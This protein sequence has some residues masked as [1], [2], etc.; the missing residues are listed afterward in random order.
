MVEKTQLNTGIIG[1]G[2]IATRGHIPGYQRL[3]GVQVLAICDVDEARA[4]S[5]AEEF[6]IPH[7]FT[8]YHDLLAM[9]EID[10]VSVCPPNR[11]HAEMSIAA[12]EAGKHVLCDKPMAMNAAEAR[13]MVAAA[14]RSGNFLTL[15]LHNRYHPE[16]Q[17]LKRIVDGGTLGEIY[18]AK[19]SLLRRTGIPGYGSWFTN[20]DL[21]GAGALFDIGVHILDL[22]LYIIGHRLPVSV[23]GATF[24]KMGTRQRG[25]GNWGIE[26]HREGQ[27]RFD[28]DD[29]ATAFMRFD[30]G[31]VLI[32]D[33]S[34][35]GYARS[36][37]RLQFWG[38]EGGAEI[39]SLWA[40]E[41]APLRL[42][43]DLNGLPTEARPAVPRASVGSYFAAIEE[44]VNCVREGRQPPITPQQGL[45]VTQILDAILESASTGR[46]VRLA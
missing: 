27:A 6:H 40:D 31:A 36:E 8:N 46:E 42:Q 23:S 30:D 3:P 32:V 15:G 29:L 26:I 41:G 7:V 24:A 1:A 37:E 9:D 28:V 45:T 5:V 14:E 20:K 10:I 21:A 4:R 39:S 44:F 12:L 11:F 25:L 43:L 35:A 13:Q 17:V 38:T 22:A 16:V 2:F 33:T 19:A 34:W 18:Y